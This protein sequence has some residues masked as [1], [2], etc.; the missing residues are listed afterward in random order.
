MDRGCP[1]S[2]YLAAYANGT[3]SDGLSLLVAAHLTYC[4]DC[5]ATVA[6]LEAV[7]GGLFEDGDDVSAPSI[8]AV[9]ARIDAAP[10]QPR[11]G[12]R[13]PAGL[14]PRPIQD[15]AGGDVDDLRWKFR[16]PGLH[17]YRLDGFE[18]EE[19]SLLR[20]RPGAGMMTHT[21]SGEEATLVLS[22]QMQDGDQVFGK[23]DV[24]IADHNDDHSPRIIGDETCYC[25]IV[26]S[27]SVRFTGR[28]SRALNLLTG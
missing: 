2:E 18:G 8:D 20:A 4:P 11:H 5:R 14:L 10:I 7:A 3:L 27:G 12:E 6:S 28:M 17:E 25:L 23:G 9:F 24:S 16:M 13:R 1:H 19:V 26:L 22:G 15:A 21:H